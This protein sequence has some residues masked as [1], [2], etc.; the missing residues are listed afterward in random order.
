MQTKSKKRQ[1][2]K[3]C[4]AEVSKEQV[5]QSIADSLLELRTQAKSADLKFLV[6]FL[7]MAFQEAFTQSSKEDAET[8][9][10]K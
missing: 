9:T 2:Q 5:A 4:D 10:V 6:Y 8:P 3:E 1:Q 7:E